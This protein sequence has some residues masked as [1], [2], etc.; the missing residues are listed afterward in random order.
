MPVALL[1]AITL[2]FGN[3]APVLSL[4][5]PSRVA[6]TVWPLPKAE[7]SRTSVKAA[8][9]REQGLDMA[10]HLVKLK[11]LRNVPPSRLQYWGNCQDARQWAIACRSA[12]G[13]T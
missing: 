1:T 11:P 13:V 12:L 3:T 5:R 10:L 2:A 7:K 6:V 4:T 8:T 9:V